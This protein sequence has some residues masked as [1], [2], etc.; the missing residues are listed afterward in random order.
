[1]KEPTQ[2]NKYSNSVVLQPNKTADTAY[3]K[4]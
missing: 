2:F 1:M 3:D 4:N